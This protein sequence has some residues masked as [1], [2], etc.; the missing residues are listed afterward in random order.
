MPGSKSAGETRRG[1][2]TVRIVLQEGS[3]AAG[4]ANKWII[5][6]KA[7]GAEPCGGIWA[8]EG[9]LLGGCSLEVIGRPGRPSFKLLRTYQ[10]VWLVQG[11]ACRAL[12]HNR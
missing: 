4:R 7:L 1:A 2:L 10:S 12:V 6:R 3:Q 8:A 11:N 9:A 5:E